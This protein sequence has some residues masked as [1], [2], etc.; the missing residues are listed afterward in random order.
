MPPERV[1]ALNPSLPRHLLLLSEWLSLLETCAW[2]DGVEC[3]L[4]VPDLDPMH[5]NIKDLIDR[6]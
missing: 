2:D 3:L 1:L 5:E 6:E 4:P